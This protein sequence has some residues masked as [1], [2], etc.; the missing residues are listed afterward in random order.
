MPPEAVKNNESRSA[1]AACSEW[2]A[3]RALIRTASRIDGGERHAEV[4]RESAYYPLPAGVHPPPAA[5]VLIANLTFQAGRRTHD[6]DRC[7]NTLI[8]PSTRIQSIIAAT[9]TASYE[10]DAIV[11]ASGFTRGSPQALLR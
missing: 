11:T 3:A 4:L 9:G 1:Y 8:T 6:G 2:P 7:W 5:L 10:I